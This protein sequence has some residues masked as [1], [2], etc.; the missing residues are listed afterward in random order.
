MAAG[1]LLFVFA[2]HQTSPCC[3]D[4]PLRNT[5][6]T[7]ISHKI[8]FLVLSTNKLSTPSMLVGLLYT[9]LNLILSRKSTY[10]ARLKYGTICYSFSFF[11]FLCHY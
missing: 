1:D 6:N 5:V 4:C 3:Q 7:I 11:S 2:I 10:L 8:M 9:I